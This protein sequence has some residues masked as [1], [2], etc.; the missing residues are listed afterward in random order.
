MLTG[1]KVLE[2]GTFTG[3]SALAFYEATRDIGTEIVTLDVEKE[4]IAIAQTAFER[5]QATDRIKIIEGDCVKTLVVSLYFGRI[6]PNFYVFPF[7]QVVAA[8]GR[9]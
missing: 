6:R 3:I 5:Y 7:I 8:A 4:F 9:F 2:L 1:N